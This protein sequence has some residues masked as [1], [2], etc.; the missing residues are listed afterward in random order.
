MNWNLIRKT[1]SD[2]WRG[3]AIYAG[4]LVAY[5]L[6]LTA[7]FPSFQNLTGVKEVLEQYPEG[8]ARFFGVESIDFSSF[9]NFM[10]MEFLG[11]MFVIIAGA[12]IFSFARYAVAGELRDG[13]LELLLAQPVERWR[14]LTSKAAVL[15]AG[16]VGLVLITV[17]SVLGLGSAFG[18]DVSY[19]GY[20]A[21]IPVAMALLVSIAGYSI[22]FSTS[23][24][25]PRWVVMASVGVTLGF[26]MMQFAAT[27]SQSLEKLGYFTIFHYYNPLKVMDSGTVPLWDVLVLLGVG[28]ACFA[29]SLWFFQR[30]DI[31]A[32]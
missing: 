17:L 25:R 26:Y 28:A 1:I 11:L 15:L 2:R 21:Y 18:I 13:T 3:T 30:K 9:N 27:S 12:F 23:L 16:I 29:A 32:K 8:M 24:N 14:I 20:L 10:T 4:A 19:S 7:M 5:V 6:M 31:T 22:L